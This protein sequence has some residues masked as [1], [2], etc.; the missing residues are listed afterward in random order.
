MADENGIE[1]VPLR[2][3]VIPLAELEKG[4]SYDLRQR[5]WAL[6]PVWPDGN[7]PPEYIRVE[8]TVG[9]LAADVESEE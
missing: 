3:E 6:L 9:A 8:T 1:C 4:K 5:V 2:D 7:G